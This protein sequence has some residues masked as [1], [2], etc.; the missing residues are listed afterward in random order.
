MDGEANDQAEQSDDGGEAPPLH[1]TN[2]VI[3]TQGVCTTP[4]NC[5]CDPPCFFL[6]RS[7]WPS[8]TLRKRPRPSRRAVENL[9]DAFP[10]CRVKCA[11]GTSAPFAPACMARW[12][13]ADGRDRSVLGRQRFKSGSPT[14]ASNRTKQSIAGGVR[15]KGHCDGKHPAVRRCALKLVS[16]SALGQS[17]SNT[18]LVDGSGLFVPKR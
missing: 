14:P 16:Y 8:T 15:G 10:T 7:R 13:F 12:V 9:S 4:Q 1:L 2:M 11:L 18:P 3:G 17:D 5:G 6:Q